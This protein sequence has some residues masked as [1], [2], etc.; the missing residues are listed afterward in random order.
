MQLSAKKSFFIFLMFLITFSAACSTSE[1]E[2]DK[3][4][5]TPVEIATPVETATPVEIAIPVGKATPAEII[6]QNVP[7]EVKIGQM[8][9]VGFRGLSVNEN[10]P[11]VQEIKKFHL[12][13]VIL[14]DYDITL[15]KRLRNIQSPKQVKTLVEGLQLVSSTP[16]FIAIDQEGGKITRLN[17]KLGFPST[18]SAQYLGRKNDLDLTD[19]KASEIAQTLSTLGINFNFA[20]VV[21]LNINPK[22]PV[23]GKLRRSFSNDPSIVTQHA[24]QFIEAHHKYKVMCALKHFPGHGSSTKDSHLGLVDV[25]DTWQAVELEPYK[26]LIPDT[27]AIMIAHVFNKHLDPKYPATMSKSI[28]TD[29]LRHEMQYDGVIVSDDM[30]MKAITENYDFKEA[31]FET[32]QAGIDIIV[33]GN[34]LKFEED[35]TQRTINSITQLI[36]EGKI[37]EKRIDESYQ[38]IQKLKSLWIPKR[39]QLMVN[40]KPINSVI[41]LTTLEQNYFP[42]MWLKPGIYDISVTKAG[43]NPQQQQIE[44][45]DQEVTI[46]MD[47]KCSGD[48]SRLSLTP[49]ESNIKIMN[50][51]VEYEPDMCLAPGYYDIFMTKLGYQPHQEW[52]KISN[53]NIIKQI[54]LKE[55][56]DDTTCLDKHRLTINVDPS[57]SQIDILNIEEKYKPGICLTAGNYNISVT[58]EDYLPQTQLIELKTHNITTNVILEI[59]EIEPLY[60]AC[61]KNQHHLTINAPVDSTIKITN[62]R[63]KYKP[64]ICLKRGKYHISVTHPSYHKEAFTIKMTDID[65]FEDVILRKK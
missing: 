50:I 35:I 55:R 19:K 14:F 38:R 22:N 43:Y 21:D 20:P 4:E 9:M 64:G 65:V 7:L 30:Q 26:D 29:K 12:G 37:T 2:I 15:R 58:K 10:S 25:S 47:L 27:D 45:K 24:F 1:N 40:A 60:D 6:P 51:G 33:I 5:S 57:D 32:I 53:Q 34:N 11:I 61:A 56:V 31:I 59:E 48:K 3:E 17:K 41:K 16:L 52:I 44:I 36:T 13:G 23:I 49:L 46:A 39:Y 18:V 8:L 63:P 42:G 54:V 28:V 62:I